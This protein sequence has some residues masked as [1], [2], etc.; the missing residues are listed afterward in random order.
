MIAGVTA[1]VTAGVAAGVVLEVEVGVVLDD[2]Q[3]KLAAECVHCAVP[4]QSQQW[5]H[6]M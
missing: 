3:P 2:G 6:G 1:G 5:A 4:W